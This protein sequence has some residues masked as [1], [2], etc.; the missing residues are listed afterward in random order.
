MRNLALGWE[1]SGIL[2]GA[3]GIGW[4]LDRWLG[5]A[6]WLLMFFLVLGLI[7][8]FLHLWAMIKVKNGSTSRRHR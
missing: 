6:P 7:G 4:L 1:F 8:G 3:A 5:T 2:F